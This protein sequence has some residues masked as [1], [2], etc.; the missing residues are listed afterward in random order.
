MK[1]ELGPDAAFFLRNTSDCHFTGVLIVQLD[2]TLDPA[3]SKGHTDNSVQLFCESAGGPCV[4]LFM[5]SLS[6]V[7]L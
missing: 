3:L 4:L 7:V 2:S 1:N 6:S 5:K